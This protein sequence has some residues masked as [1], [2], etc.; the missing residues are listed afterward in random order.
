MTEA[1]VS[2]GASVVT[3]SRTVTRTELP[4]GARC[5]APAIA[6]ALTRRTG[7]SERIMPSEFDEPWTDLV[8]RFEGY[9]EVPPAMHCAALLRLAMPRWEDRVVVSS[10]W[11]HGLRFAA[12]GAELPPNEQVRVQWSNGTFEFKLTRGRQAG[13]VTGDRCRTK[14]GATLLDAFLVQLAGGEVPAA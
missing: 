4:L 9:F 3:R 11:V 12:A 1:P 2:A 8:A 6:L 14:N 10:W 5:S 13:L 7:H